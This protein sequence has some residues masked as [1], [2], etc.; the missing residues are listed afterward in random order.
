MH[1][2]SGAPSQ[3]A[4]AGCPYERD[5]DPGSFTGHM[6]ANRRDGRYGRDRLN[7]GR[8]CVAHGVVMTTA[9]KGNLP[10]GQAVGL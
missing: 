10:H 9:G 6:H 5:H 2:P 1:S 3:P 8:S 4:L 7:C